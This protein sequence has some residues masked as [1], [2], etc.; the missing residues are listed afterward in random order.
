[1]TEKV[2]SGNSSQDEYSY[3]NESNRY[4]PQLRDHAS[5]INKIN[6]MHGFRSVFFCSKIHNNTTDYS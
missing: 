5:N 4:V 1:M 3:L 2:Q 6:L